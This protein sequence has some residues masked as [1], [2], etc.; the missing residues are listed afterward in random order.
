MKLPSSLTTVTPLSK[1]LALVLFITLPFLGFFIGM[2]YQQQM[3]SSESEVI[4]IS[5][6]QTP[7]TTQLNVANEWKDFIDKDFQLQYPRTWSSQI[8]NDTLSFQDNSG[9]TIMT[10]SSFNPA[11]VGITY[12]GANAN[13]PRCEGAI[14]WGNGGPATAIFSK[15]SR[16]ISLTLEE[17]TPETKEI[18][19]HIASTF[20]F[21]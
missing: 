8:I 5:P 16:G 14:D 12:C 20:Q 21:L 9:K 19:R 1:F 2:Q 10:L 6:S 13:D 11:L 3:Y 4:S 15:S 18:F 7:P 17:L